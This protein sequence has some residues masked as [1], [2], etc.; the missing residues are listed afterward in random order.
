MSGQSAY[1]AAADAAASAAG[2]PS[3]I[4]SALVSK[5]SSW[6]A[7][8]VGTSGEIGLTQ[9]MPNTANSLGVNAYDPNANLKGGATFLASLFKK[10]GDWTSA[11]SAYNTGS[12]TS[13]VGQQ[14]AQSILS[15]AGVAGSADATPASAAP[16]GSISG[17]LGAIGN[18]ITKIQSIEFW[19]TA[20]VYIIAIVVLLVLT[21]AAVWHMFSS[22]TKSAI[23]GAA[24][25]G[26]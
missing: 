11:L 21:V 13:A 25:A 19:K 8:A 3:A 20:G 4:F 14:Y 5:E 16:T 1:Q 15:A 22:E 26:A 18:F 23:K 2:I 9:L 7:Y 17:A 10:Y 24:L 12:P 6:N